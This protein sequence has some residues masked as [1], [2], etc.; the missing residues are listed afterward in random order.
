MIDVHYFAR[1]R[2]QLA[3]NQENLEAENLKTASDVM[4]LLRQRGDI[5]GEVFAEDQ[6]IMVAVN[7]EMCDAEQAVKD[8]DEV[9]FF[10][11]VTG[12]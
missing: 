2:E 8:G 10:P 5:W 3:T 1:L 7:Q 6:L 9:A 11:P 12:G 4:A